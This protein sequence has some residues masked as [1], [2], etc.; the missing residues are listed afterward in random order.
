MVGQAE[1]R[2]RAHQRRRFTLGGLTT[3]M[4]LGDDTRTEQLQGALRALAPGRRFASGICRRG[5]R[6]AYAVGS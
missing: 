3:D 2:C 6:P 5:S 1:E 4:E